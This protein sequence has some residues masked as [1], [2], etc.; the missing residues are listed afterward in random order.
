MTTEFDRLVNTRENQKEFHRG[1]T[2]MEIT[3]MLCA[4]MQEQG[5][6]RADLAKRLGVTKGSVSQML[7]GDR[8]LTVNSISDILF[9]LGLA[10]DARC[11][12]MNEAPFVYCK[13][14]VS[15]LDHQQIT[16]EVE[17]FETKAA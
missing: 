11:R 5:V 15:W 8:N 4:A 16:T 17:F 9:E 3:E 7:N 6:S 13:S 10:L 12:G 1:R 14:N 2:L